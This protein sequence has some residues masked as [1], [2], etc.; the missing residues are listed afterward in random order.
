MFEHEAGGELGLLD[1]KLEVQ[2]RG[3]AAGEK[4]QTKHKTDQS[5]SA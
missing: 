3:F 5:Q 2:N 4:V 1:E